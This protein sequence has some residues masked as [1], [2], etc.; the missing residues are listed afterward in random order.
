MILNNLSKNLEMFQ[1]GGLDGVTAVNSSSFGA[2]ENPFEQLRELKRKR[3]ELD[4]ASKD[5]RP[6]TANSTTPSSELMAEPHQKNHQLAAAGAPQGPL[7]STN[8]GT[9]IQMNKVAHDKEAS[10]SSSAPPPHH[11]LGLGSKQQVSMYN[12]VK[13]YVKLKDAKR[14]WQEAA[15]AAIDANHEYKEKKKEADNL[16]EQVKGLEEGFSKL[17]AELAEKISKDALQLQMLYA[18]I[19]GWNLKNRLLQVISPGSEFLNLPLWDT[20]QLYPSLQ[21]Q[22]NEGLALIG[23]GHPIDDK[24]ATQSNDPPVVVPLS[25]FWHYNLLDN[26]SQCEPR[27]FC[28][29]EDAANIAANSLQFQAENARANNVEQEDDANYQRMDEATEAEHWDWR[30]VLRALGGKD[31]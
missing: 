9:Q 7:F 4:G 12:L 27:V 28:T 2:R 20:I 23:Q 14:R 25:K 31:P 18:V 5:E 17:K 11:E 13:Q 29:L 8:R 1:T 24:V 19:L 22:F 6:A 16:N 3:E 15:A 26:V 10:T 30:S 21:N